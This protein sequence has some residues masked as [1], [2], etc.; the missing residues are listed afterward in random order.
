MHGGISWALRLSRCGPYGAGFGGIQQVG[1][2]AD[3]RMPT[4]RAVHGQDQSCRVKQEC[5]TYVATRLSA[6]IYCT[7]IPARACSP[8]C[9]LPCRV[10]AAPPAPLLLG[11]EPVGAADSLP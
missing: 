5:C 10:I 6:Y 9:L 8:A 11:G 7:F 4:Q 1:T 3:W 2:P